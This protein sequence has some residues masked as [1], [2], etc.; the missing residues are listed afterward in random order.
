MIATHP[1]HNAYLERLGSRLCRVTKKEAFTFLE[2]EVVEATASLAAILDA[3]DEDTAVGSHRQANACLLA[4]LRLEAIGD[5]ISSV[6][7][8]ELRVLVPMLR[9]L[10]EGIQ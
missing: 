6:A 2:E 9:D 5:A 7:S 1:L 10:K 8:Q 3:P 4:L